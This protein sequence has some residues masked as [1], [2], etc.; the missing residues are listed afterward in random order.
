MLG[1]TL[2]SLDDRRDPGLMA[3]A[4]IS[5]TSWQQRSGG[6]ADASVAE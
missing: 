3:V 2:S 5:Y 6:R 1:R 4:V